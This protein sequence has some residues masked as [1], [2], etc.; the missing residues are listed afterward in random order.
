MQPS[1]VCGEE[2]S[3]SR[4]PKLPTRLECVFYVLSVFGSDRV[5]CVYYIIG[6]NLSNVTPKTSCPVLSIVLFKGGAKQSIFGLII[7]L[8]VG[9]KVLLS[10]VL[11]KGGAKPSIFGLIITLVVG[12]KVS[13]CSDNSL[14]NAPRTRSS[15]LILPETSKQA[16]GLSAN[17]RQ[18][19]PRR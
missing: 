8:V 14:Y 15:D 18:R 5:T 10:I 17:S 19:I 11:F 12:D 7:T 6:P 16:P 1:K 4:D 3:S 13:M 2:A 9:E